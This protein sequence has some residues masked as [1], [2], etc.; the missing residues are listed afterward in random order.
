MRSSPLIAALCLLSTTLTA[1]NG[2]QAE[3]VNMLIDLVAWGDDIYGLHLGSLAD[4]DDGVDALSFRYGKEPVRYSGPPLLAI[5]QSEGAENEATPFVMTAKDEE[6]LARPLL[7]EAAQGPSGNGGEGQISPLLAERRMEEPSLVALVELPT[8]S[9]RA[10]LL[11]APAA[12]GTYVGHTIHDDPSRLP[13]GQLLVHNLCENEIAMKF[14]EGELVV[15][16]PR[17]SYLVKPSK[18]YLAYTTYKL[19]YRDEGVWKV[20]ESNVIRL[21]PDEQTQMFILKSDNQ[22]FRSSSGGRSGY[23]QM[24]TLRRRTQ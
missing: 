1:A 4:V 9:R 14:G 22:F 17:E 11:L 21:S 16:N 20:Q 5:Y 23:L 24:I 18:E 7:A 10:T 15:L 2:Q 8:N 19:G 6:N 13:V 12:S 3:H